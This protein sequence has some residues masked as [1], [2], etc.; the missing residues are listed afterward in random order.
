MG[1]V[2]FNPPTDHLDCDDFLI[3]DLVCSASGLTNP[4]PHRELRGSEM[5]NP[6]CDS[7]ESV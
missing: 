1:S 5:Q 4:P 6:D 3:E 7:D 2:Q